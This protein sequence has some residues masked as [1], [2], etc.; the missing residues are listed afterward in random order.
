[1]RGWGGWGG[2]SGEGNRG[3]S[4]WGFKGVRMVKSNVGK[5][6]MSFCF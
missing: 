5:G 6:I 1:M 4:G 3:S 2:V